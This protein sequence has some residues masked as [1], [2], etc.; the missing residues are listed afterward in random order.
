[1]PTATKN[2]TTPT[3][4]SAIGIGLAAL[5]AELTVPAPANRDESEPETP[6]SHED[7][8]NMKF[9]DVGAFVEDIPSRESFVEWA[10]D[11]WGAFLLASKTMRKNDTEMAAM[12]AE[13]GEETAGVLLEMFDSRA[14]RYEAYAQLYK[15]ASLRVTCGMARFYRDNGVE[16]GA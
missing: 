11:D 2:P 8:A 1:M 7:R 5:A 15:A 14:K 12:P 10:G 9:D 4:R 16:F 3:R 13:V 6:M